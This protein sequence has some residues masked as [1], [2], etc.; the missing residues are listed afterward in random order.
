MKCELCWI[1]TNG[2]INWWPKCRADIDLLRN[3]QSEF[4]LLFLA[5]TAASFFPFSINC[6]TARWKMKSS[7]YTTRRILFVATLQQADAVAYCYCRKVLVSLFDF[8]LGFTLLLLLPSV[9]ESRLQHS[10]T[11]ATTNI[12]NMLQAASSSRL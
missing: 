6:C 3:Y 8:N 7:R 5:L 1:L 10:P 12:S 9:C 4:E 11:T 2:R